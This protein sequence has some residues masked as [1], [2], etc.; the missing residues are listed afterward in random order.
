MSF[1]E[2]AAFLGVAYFF[3]TQS[4]KSPRLV[5]DWIKRRFET[6]KIHKKALHYA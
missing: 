1:H 5:I 4:A 6:N 3:D 2:C